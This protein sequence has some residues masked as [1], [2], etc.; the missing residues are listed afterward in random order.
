MR[1]VADNLNILL[2]HPRLRPQNCNRKA[3]TRALA[4]WN[5]CGT[6]LARHHLL[7]LLITTNTLFF[8]HS[9]YTHHAV[10][11]T[12][13]FMPKQWNLKEG[14]S[15]GVGTTGAGGGGRAPLN[16]I[17]RGAEPPEKQH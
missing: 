1:R 5:E 6:V 4:S 9:S 16:I 2:F 10:I 12:Q 13:P 8:P 7:I 15:T 11:V 17:T 3:G 14:L